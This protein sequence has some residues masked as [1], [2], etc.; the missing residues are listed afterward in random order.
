[1]SPV[2]TFPLAGVFC[3]ALLMSAPAAPAADG[4]P[5]TPLYG[6]G[7]QL[8]GRVLRDIFNCYGS[9]GGG[10]T[11]AGLT[12]AAECNLVTPYNSE[13]EQLYLGSGNGRAAFVNRD[14]SRLTDGP[15]LPDPAPVPSTMDFGPFYG[16]GRG[17]SWA[18]N[19]ADSGPFFPSLS[20][21]ASEEP[22][23]ATD[24]ATYSAMSGGHWGAP[25]QVPAFIASVSIPYQPTAAWKEAGDA[26][27]GSDSQFDLATETLCGV[28]TG[29]I[30]SWNSNAFKPA[31]GGKQLGTGPIRVVYR[32][33]GGGTFLFS[34]AL[35][36]QC[37]LTT[38]P[39]PAA[40]QSAT[41]NSP[42][43]GND[44]FFDNLARA[45]LL[46][47]NFVA[48][49]DGQTMQ[50]EIK[51]G[52]G[53][54]GYDAPDS[55]QFVNPAGTRAANLQAFAT[56]GGTPVFLAPIP[57]NTAPI[58]AKRPPPSSKAA[59][60]DAAHATGQ[61]PFLLSVDGICADNPLNWGLTFPAPDLRT[62]YP[63]GGFIF[64]NTYGCP[65][66]AAVRDAL[67]GTVPGRLGLLRWFFGSAAENGSR[68]KIVLNR[69]G[70]VVLPGNWVG[71]AKKLLAIAPATR[72]GIPG[73]AK[74]GCA[75]VS[76][77]A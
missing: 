5:L 64:L 59:S 67:A 2:S 19:G 30:T 4:Q 43:T 28:F 57:K 56:L 35:I 53:S 40:W 68:V 55:V 7:S 23:S 50:S 74:T 1:M 41:G 52:P 44:R 17:T 71:A 21:T 62:A 10:D 77:G 65:A 76:G 49:A 34:N 16:T 15:T 73:Q 60:C 27:A 66:S 70:F 8:A 3:L 18:P 38:Y 46:P 45:G 39:I 47:A 37:A 29:A 48:L 42:G 9:H 13:S 61:A 72:I 58:I 6:G 14:P 12:A 33:Q 11:L 51:S 54:I 69:N 63:I 24:I 75:T 25:I 31:N 36:R 26:V 22:L 20:F 32:R